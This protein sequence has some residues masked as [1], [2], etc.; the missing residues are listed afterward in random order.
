ME[1]ALVKDVQVRQI[2]AAGCKYAV[3]IVA[4]VQFGAGDA[5][6][7]Q[8]LGERI[9]VIGQ[10]G[11]KPVRWFGHWVPGTQ[12]KPGDALQRLVEIL[13]VG[14]VA[15]KDGSDVVQLDQANGGVHIVHV[16]FVANLL[17]IDIGARHRTVNAKPAKATPASQQLLHIG[18]VVAGE[19]ATVHCGHVLDGLQGK[20]DEFGV[21]ANGLASVACTQ[22][23]GCVFDHRYAMCL[24]YCPNSRNVCGY[25]AIVHHHNRLGA[26][27]DAVGDRLGGEVARAGAYIGPHNF[28][29]RMQDGHV[30]GLGCH[31]GREHFI[32]RLHPR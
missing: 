14:N 7:S 30:G 20:H 5:M 18:M 22:C 27:G 21:A 11:V 19:H 1:H 32:T 28:G 13:A 3:Q 12:I 23:V 9:G 4:L 16:V 15:C 8:M 25:A 31:G 10:H 6:G 2:A 29:A 24:G 17:H 26:A